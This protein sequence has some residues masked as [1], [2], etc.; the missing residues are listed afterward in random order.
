MRVKLLRT[1]VDILEKYKT[2]YKYSCGID[3]VGRGPIAGPVVACSVVMGKNIV[4]GVR[5]SKKLSDK[6][7]RLLASD[8]YSNAIAIGYGIVDEKTIDDINIRNASHLAMKIAFEKMVDKEGNKFIP[9]LALIDAELIDISVDQ[10]GIISGDDLVYEISCASILAKILRDD[11]MV[12]Y[13]SEYPE[14]SFEA[15][16]GYGTKKHYEAIDK[17]GLTPIHRISFMKKYYDNKKQID[18]DVR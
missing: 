15:H 11:M 16:K 2:K 17:F 1:Q 4:E 7:R 18:G 5:D 12:A 13:S 10:I 6:K 9:D 14:Y 8:I 3:E